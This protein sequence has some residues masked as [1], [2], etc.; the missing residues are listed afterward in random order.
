M[1]SDSSTPRLDDRT[2][3]L[4]LHDLHHAYLLLH[5]AFLQ[6][7]PTLIPNLEPMPPSLKCHEDLHQPAGFQPYDPAPPDNADIEIPTDTDAEGELFQIAADQPLPHRAPS[8]KFPSPVRHLPAPE[9]DHIPL[10]P[11]LQ[12]STLRVDQGHPPGFER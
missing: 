11:N 9:E 1:A 4:F 12:T 8:A 7:P 6:L 10:P 3:R 2:F 5:R